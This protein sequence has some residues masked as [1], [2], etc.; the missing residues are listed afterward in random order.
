MLF[1]VTIIHFIILLLLL[2]L[3]H[4]CTLIVFSIRYWLQYIVIIIIIDPVLYYWLLLLLL[5]VIID[6]L[7]YYGIYWPTLTIFIHYSTFICT[8]VIMKN[9]INDIMVKWSVL[10]SIGR[11]SLFHWPRGSGRRWPITLLLVLLLCYSVLYGI[12]TLMMTPLLLLN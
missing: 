3:T 8:F 5:C 9:D 2:T 11:Y 4:Y 6:T 12:D 10:A 1:T 7:T